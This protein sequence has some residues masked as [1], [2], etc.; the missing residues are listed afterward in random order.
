MVF[1]EIV[2]GLCHIFGMIHTFQEFMFL[3]HVRNTSLTRRIIR[4][5]YILVSLIP[6]NVSPGDTI[7]DI[8]YV[9]MT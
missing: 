5:I 6:C 8:Y 9:I 3:K 7:A 4:M 2:C 1:W